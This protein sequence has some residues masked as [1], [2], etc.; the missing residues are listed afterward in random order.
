MREVPCDKEK[1]FKKQNKVKRTS[2][3]WCCFGY[4]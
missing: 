4:L 3:K 2:T 1:S